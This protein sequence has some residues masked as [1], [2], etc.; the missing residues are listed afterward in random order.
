MSTPMA[1]VIRRDTAHPSL[2]QRTAARSEDWFDRDQLEE[3]RSYFRPLKRVRL[4]SAIA[5][6]LALVLFA[7]AGG[8]RW[9]DDLV[10]GGWVVGLVAVLVAIN[11]VV[12][13]VGVPFSAWVAL[14]YDKAHGLSD[15]TPSM[16]AQDTAKELVLGVVLESV[17]L[18][19]VF[20][21]IRAFEAWWFLG[22]AAF[23]AVQVVLLFLYPVVIMPRFNKFTP[24]EEGPLRERIEEVARIAAT[25]IEGIYVMDASKRS[26]RGNAF[27]AGFGKTKRVVLFDTILDMP[28]ESIANIVAHEIGHYRLH[29]TL[30][31]LPFMGALLFLAL[32]VTDVVASNET[33]LEWTDGGSLGDPASLPLFLIAFGLAWT[34]LS[35][36]QAWWSRYQ[37]RAAD[38]EA[39]ELL[40]DPTSFM[41]IWPR[42]V[43]LNKAELEPS[44]W[45]RL[46][47]GHPEVAERMQFGLRWAELNGVPAERPAKTRVDDPF[48]AVRDE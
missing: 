44:W 6:N 11:V 24:L 37:E 43:T 1:T 27:V 3:M 13:A 16:F 28:N 35:L 38:L 9:A 45:A 41:A 22:W 25:E 33:L 2:W 31:S 19:P 14:R 20:A 46:N 30:L 8:G 18:L 32:V 10:G 40:G 12:T 23:M 29:H 17:M 5:T 48:A 34:A 15:Q 39:L 47:H 36:A 7:L 42:F 21:A 26:R 4:A